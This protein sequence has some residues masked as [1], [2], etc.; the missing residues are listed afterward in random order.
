MVMIA[1]SMR[2]YLGTVTPITLLFPSST[3]GIGVRFDNGSTGGFEPS[4]LVR[5]AEPNHIKACRDVPVFLRYAL[6]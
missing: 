5:L 2:G 1:S 6:D 4:E 3:S